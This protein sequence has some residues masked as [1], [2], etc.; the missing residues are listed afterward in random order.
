MF[1]DV[2]RPG[3]VCTSSGRRTLG[4]RSLERGWEADI[5]WC[6]T[7][8]GSGC[9]T[10]PWPASCY[11][12]W[13]VTSWRQKKAK[14][15]EGASFSC[16]CFLFSWPFEYLEKCFMCV[17]F[18]IFLKTKPHLGCY[19]CITW[20]SRTGQECWDL[21]PNTHEAF[22]DMRRMYTSGSYRCICPQPGFIK[23]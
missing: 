3:P 16:F 12:R 4:G 5:C 1:P 8:S 23:D 13:N 11:W 14:R 10:N 9:R 20:I 22:Q 2:Y 18:Y 15:W 19:P 21:S 17:L 6:N 7:S